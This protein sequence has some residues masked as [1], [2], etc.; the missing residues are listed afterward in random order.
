MDPVT[1]RWTVTV[2]VTCLPDCHDARGRRH[3]LAALLPEPLP[4]FPRSNWWNLDVSMAPLDP[5]SFKLHLRSSDASR[6]AHPDF[7]G[8]ASPGSVEIYGFPYVVVDGSMPKQ[9]VQFQYSARERRGESPCQSTAIRFTQFLH[10]RRP[11]NLTGWRAARRA[12]SISGTTQRSPLAHRRSRQ[13]TSLR[14]LQRLLR[15]HARGTR[16]QARSST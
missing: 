4:L 6:S 8:E 11:L 7:G 3:S 2:S 12:T 1:R 16:V 13:P 9:A 5:D 14:A 15:R 10:K